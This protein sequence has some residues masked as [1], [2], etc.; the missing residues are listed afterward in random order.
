[1]G[2]GGE[3]RR[4][5]GGGR[6]KGHEEGSI[7]W[8]TLQEFSKEMPTPHNLETTLQCADLKTFSHS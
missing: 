1:M 5:K 2:A 8:I 7:K 3:G 6:G 4:E